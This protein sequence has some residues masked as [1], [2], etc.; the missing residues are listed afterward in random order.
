MIGDLSLFAF[1]IAL[2]ITGTLAAVGTFIV[3]RLKGDDAPT[4]PDGW[5][6]WLG[7]MAPYED[8]DD[9]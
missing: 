9:A 4:K 3:Y 2:V 7:S 6:E 1:Y 5:D 8:L